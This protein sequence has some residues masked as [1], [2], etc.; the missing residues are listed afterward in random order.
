M[1]HTSNLDALGASRPIT[2]L[3]MLALVDGRKPYVEDNRLT[4]E[5]RLA[6][7][8]IRDALAA[9]LPRLEAQPEF[10]AAGPS[11]DLQHQMEGLCLGQ[12]NAVLDILIDHA[13]RLGVDAEQNLRNTSEF[14]LCLARRVR[15]MDARY[16][17][18]ALDE[19]VCALTSV[20]GPQGPGPAALRQAA[21]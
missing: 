12:A 21:A 18:G 8:E 5:A 2:G 7:A 16:A 20:L 9:F 13:G 14:L 15:S 1:T 10:A 11:A 3:A 17:H 6:V 4:P 19:E